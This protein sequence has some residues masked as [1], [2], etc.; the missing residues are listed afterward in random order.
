MKTGICHIVAAGESPLPRF[1]PGQGDLVIAADAGYEALTRLGLRPDLA[2]GDFDSCAVPV[3]GV[4]VIRH[5]AIKDET[6]TV[7]AV[8]TGFERG[9]DTFLIYCGLG[10]RLDH[11]LANLQ[12]LVHIAKR[13]GRG[14][15]V[16]DA[17]HACA[18]TDGEMTFPPTARGNLSVFAADGD[19]FGVT[20]RG[21]FY[22]LTDA[23]V[24]TDF[25]IGVSNLFTGAPARVAVQSGTL[26]VLWSGEFDNTLLDWKRKP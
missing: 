7:L 6:D 12:T 3:T 21:L 11:T 25:P 14:F 23:R 17:E 4:P 5:P 15:L 1:A 18:V 16:G 26:L 20:L 9:F 19:A 22:P 8:R 24:T 13:G 10:G 2:V